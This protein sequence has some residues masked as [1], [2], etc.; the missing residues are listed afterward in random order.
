MHALT[1]KD[2]FV[3]ITL[4]GDTTES[5]LGVIRFFPSE[6]TID[7]PS[8]HRLAQPPTLL[9][10]ACAC[11]CGPAC[12]ECPRTGL[13]IP[14]RPIQ[15]IFCMCTIS[16]S[17]VRVCV[18][19]TVVGSGAGASR[20]QRRRCSL[21][22]QNLQAGVYGIL[23]SI[24]AEISRNPVVSFT[25]NGPFSVPCSNNGRRVSESECRRHP[26]PRL[27]TS[28]LPRPVIVALFL[29]PAFY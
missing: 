26:R 15:T 21:P 8:T 19:G 29:S 18:A 22:R 24:K 2:V 9:P 16:L 13:S 14:R 12:R 1:I 5:F 3:G 4:F 10:L 27:R 23:N 7:P 20:H 17:A 28:S 11:E 6:Q 25:S